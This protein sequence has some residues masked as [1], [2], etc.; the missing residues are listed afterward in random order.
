MQCVLHHA[1]T[2]GNFEEL[3]KKELIKFVPSRF[4]IDSGFIRTLENPDFISKQIDTIFYYNDIGFPMA[5]TPKMKIFPIEFDSY[6]KCMCL[7]HLSNNL[8]VGI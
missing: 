8:I 7:A 3:I 5:V 6:A 1:E 2:G 4:G